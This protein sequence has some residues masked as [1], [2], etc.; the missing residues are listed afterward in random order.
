MPLLRFPIDRIVG[1][2]DWDGSWND[3]TGPVLATGDL[4]VPDGTDVG[5]CVEAVI[6]SRPLGN[7]TW[8]AE[9]ALTEVDLDFLLDLPPDA[10][11]SVTIR[12]ASEE[13][14]GALAHLAPGLRQRTLADTGFTDGVLPIIATLTR[15]THLQTW[16]N[17]FTDAGIQVLA[18][19][20][21]LER[22]DLE[23][24]SLSVTAFD[25]VDQ[26]PCLGQLGLQDVPLSSG[27]LVSLRR[28]LPGVR[29]NT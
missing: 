25:F 7:G 8:Q 5:I 11:H 21:S 10:L 17:H 3:A 12:R 16:G 6:E 13:S 28:R 23:E 19:L 29:L 1:T 18:P 24:E 14:T 15:L 27:D 2:L 26:L 22:L 9:G 20:V 4:L